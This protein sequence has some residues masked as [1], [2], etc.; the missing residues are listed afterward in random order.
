LATAKKGPGV[1]LTEDTRQQPAKLEDHIPGITFIKH[2]LPAG[3]QEFQYMLEHHRAV[4]LIEEVNRYDEVKLP[5]QQ[6]IRGNIRSDELDGILGLDR[7]AG[8]GVKG[9]GGNGVSTVGHLYKLPREETLA[10][11]NFKDGLPGQ[12]MNQ[13]PEGLCTPP[14]PVLGNRVPL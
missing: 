10:A 1:C 2:D 4:T 6:C 8:K 7:L 12:E 14:E 3:L 13:M 9:H 11:P 5:P